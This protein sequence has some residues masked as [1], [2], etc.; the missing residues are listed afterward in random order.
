MAVP[1]VPYRM[2]RDQKEE[3]GERVEVCREEE[4]RALTECTEGHGVT[5]GQNGDGREA[6]LLLLDGKFTASPDALA[7]QSR[8]QG[9]LPCTCPS[10]AVERSGD[11]LT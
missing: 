11:P 9:N 3:W 8:G 6:W 7:G 10:Q 5:L 2:N 4:E 1:G